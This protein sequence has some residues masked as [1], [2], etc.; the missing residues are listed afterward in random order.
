MFRSRSKVAVAV[1]DVQPADP[2]GQALAR[3]LIATADVG[4]ENSSGTLERWH[5]WSGRPAAATRDGARIDLGQRGPDAA[6]PGLDLTAIAMAGLLSI[7]GYADEPPVK[8]AVTVA[9]HLT[10]VFAAQAALAGVGGAAAHWARSGARRAAARLGAAPR[11]HVG[12]VDRSGVPSACAPA[13]E[14][15]TTRRA[16]STR[17]R[18]RFVAIAIDRDEHLRSLACS[19]GS[20][21]RTRRASPDRRKVDRVAHGD[22]GGE[23]YGCRSCPAAVVASASEGQRRASR[24]ANTTS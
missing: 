8:S 11:D 21:G 20:R 18:R 22:V 24:S 7:T 1:G 13:I 10:A 5:L 3:R 12:G 23:C 17:R 19:V 14:G 4:C 2:R 6:R 16:V 9:D 15:L